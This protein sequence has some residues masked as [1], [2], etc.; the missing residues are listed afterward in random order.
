MLQWL[1]QS[2][3]AHPS[4]VS[5]QVPSGL[6]HPEEQSRYDAL[7]TVKR[8][9]DWL[10]GRWT[11][12]RLLQAVLGGGQAIPLS[13]I[14]LDND[15]RGVPIATAPRALTAGQLSISHGHG[16]AFCGVS[17]DA[18]PVGVDLEYVEARR[19]VF[20]AD[21]FTAAEQRLARIAPSRRR[22]EIITAIWSG[23]EAALKA[24]QLGLSVDTRSVTCLL[25]PAATAL[26]WTPFEIALDRRRLPD[27]SLSLQGWWRV[28][29]GFVYTVA[30]PAG[31]PPP[32]DRPVAVPAS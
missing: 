6:F 31:G 22:D 3:G 8:R 15:R 1:I 24:L 30:V 7:A 12:K 25:D 17:M 4:L 10:L 18:Y 23:K 16:R 11:A 20:V 14:V 21:F 26:R 2:I 5:G 28:A 9:R 13:T 29:D 32:A 19:E 27:L